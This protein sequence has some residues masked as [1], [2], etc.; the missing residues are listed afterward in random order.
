MS[1]R[2]TVKMLHEEMKSL[3]LKIFKEMEMLKKKVEYLESALEDIKR[4]DK[5]IVKPTHDV[6]KCKKCK[7]T[8]D[9]EVDLNS[10]I[11]TSHSTKVKCKICTKIFS[12][13]NE[14]EAHIES[15]QEEI[16]TEKKFLK[17]SFSHS[18]VVIPVHCSGR[19]NNLE[20]NYRYFVQ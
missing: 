3:K 6:M 11:I 2:V 15:E 19:E 8:F 18:S 5:S 1:S 10:H 17:P 7:K 12:K 13:N 9:S 20:I 16:E 4:K 14:L